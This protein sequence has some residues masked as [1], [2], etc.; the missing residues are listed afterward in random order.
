MWRKQ[1]QKRGK[2]QLKLSSLFMIHL[3]INSDCEAM[4]FERGQAIKIGNSRSA[5]RKQ[6]SGK[7]Q[8]KLSTVFVIHFIYQL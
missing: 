4:D 5:S 7:L 3:F 2:L 8:L 1:K 6:S